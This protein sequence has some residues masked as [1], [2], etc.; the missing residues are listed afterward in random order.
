M[1]GFKEALA[2][3]SDYIDSEDALEEELRF[4][5]LNNGFDRETAFEAAAFYVKMREAS[6]EI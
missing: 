6:P 1:K 2:M 4:L 5:L 3:I